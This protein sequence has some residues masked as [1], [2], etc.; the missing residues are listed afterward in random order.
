MP[1][2]NDLRAV[3]AAMHQA[4][5]LYRPAVFWDAASATIV[6]ELETEGIERFR[7]LSTP[8]SYFVPTWGVPVSGFTAEQVQALTDGLQGDFPNAKKAHLALAQFLS[9]EMAAQAD[10]RVLKAADD[11]TRLPHLHTFTESEVGTPVGQMSFEGRRFSRSSMNYLLGMALLKKHLGA[12]LPRVV[13]EVGGGFGTLGELLAASGMPGWQYIDVDIPPTS[14]VAEW[15]LR[16]VLGEAN[17]TGWAQTHAESAL[18]VSSLPQAAVLAAWQI[19]QLQGQ[20][21]LFVNFI[22]FQEMEPHI[23]RNYLAQAE[24]LQARW[25]LLRNLR[26][27]KPKRVPGQQ[28]GVDTP[29]LGDDYITMLPGYELIERSTLPF[30]Y[31]TV[32]GFHSEMLLLKRRD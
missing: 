32:D 26:E 23:V 13:L 6:T 18:P 5:E 24:R 3:C 30:G 27:G 4:P 1:A 10:Y 8:L 29:V 7:S 17:V 20:V 14:F 16:Q 25:V 15:Y 21:D 12:E 31:K 28:H 11:P 2:Y 19:E 9:G 22:S